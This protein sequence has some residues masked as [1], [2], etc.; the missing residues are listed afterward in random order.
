MNSEVTLR[1]YDATEAR[2]IFEDLVSLYMEVY[3]HENGEF[4]EESRIREQLESHLKANGFSLVAAYCDAAL[5]GYV[6]GFTLPSDSQWWHGLVTS[7]P[8]DSI[9]ETGERTFG[10][11]ELVVHPSMQRKGVGHSLHN[12][13]LNARGEERATLLV[14]QDNE[15]AESAYLKWGW[16]YFGQLQPS[17]QGAPVLNALIRELPL[18]L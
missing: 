8:A 15:V 10:L 3:A 9:R 11:C 17:W 4:F 5:V 7:V 14:E 18:D 16:K 12:A 2:G 6:Y 13:L 1:R